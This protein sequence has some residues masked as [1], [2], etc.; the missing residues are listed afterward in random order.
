MH[1]WQ[2]SLETKLSEGKG[3][4]IEW[5]IIF[6]DP[7]RRCTISWEG[8]ATSSNKLSSIYRAFSLLMLSRREKDLVPLFLMALVTRC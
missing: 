6:A 3:H 2:R 1:V 8:R 5:S 4:G 7:P